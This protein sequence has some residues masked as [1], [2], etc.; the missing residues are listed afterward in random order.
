[1]KTRVLRF[2]ETGGP[3]VLKLEEIDLA[4]PGRGQA[5][6]RH[7]A[8]GLNFIDVYHRTGLY[9]LP[10]PAIPGSEGAGV[11]EEI[12]P[13]VTTVK[14]GDR[15]VYSGAIGSYAERRLVPSEKLIVL[16]D[17]IDDRQAAA[18]FLKGTTAHYLLYRTFPVKRG[19]TVLFHAAAGGVGLIACQWANALGAVVIGTVGS[20][21]KAALAK[22]NGCHHVINYRTE[23][24]VDRVK[25]ITGGAGCDVV[26]DSVAKDTFPGS[27]DCL[28]PLGMWALFGQ[29][30]G[31]IPPIDISILQHK[32]SLFA[33]RATAI[34]YFLKRADLETAAAE[35]FRMVGSGQIKI[36]LNQTFPLFEAGRA[37]QAL[38]G[39]STTGATVLTI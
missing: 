21:E 23:N 17:S 22:A 27:L 7:T 33:T 13:E 5:L 10:L 16:P 18:M 39:R 19:D 6:L 34:H 35:L 2:H 32:G 9:K 11:V 26:Y 15:V 8:V 24:F 31:P 14:P 30:S 29:S 36:H 1:M 12:G 25:E 3:E 28:R 38:E 4:P 37:H 20:E